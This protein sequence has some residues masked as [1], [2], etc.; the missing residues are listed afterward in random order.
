MDTIARE[1]KSDV[2]SSFLC[3]GIS[4]KVIVIRRVAPSTFVLKNVLLREVI[5]F[6][7]TYLATPLNSN[8]RHRKANS[9]TYLIWNL[10]F[11]SSS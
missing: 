5:A 4:A 8:F 11:S 3:D 7:V 6:A 10:L 2:L 1:K 9:C